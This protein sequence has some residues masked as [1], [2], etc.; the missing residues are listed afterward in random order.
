MANIKANIIHNLKGFF[1]Y[2]SI[3]HNMFPKMVFNIKNLDIK[4]IGFVAHINKIRLYLF[5]Y[6]KSHNRL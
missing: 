4:A 1:A 2:K 5:V 3:K 6:I